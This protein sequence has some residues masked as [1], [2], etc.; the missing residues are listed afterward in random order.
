MTQYYL[1]LGETARDE[2]NFD[3]ARAI[4]ITS[5]RRRHGWGYERP[6]FQHIACLTCK[7]GEFEISARVFG[8][9]QAGRDRANFPWLEIE[10]V[11]LAP[12]FSAACQALGQAAYDAAF[13]TGYAMT[14]D[15]AVAFALEICKSP[16]EVGAPISNS[17]L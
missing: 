6:E 9:A 15:Q 8:A 11:K 13:A 5:L 16:F 17:S 1:L 2:D 3:E 7:T 10:R 4:Y 12:Y 14:A